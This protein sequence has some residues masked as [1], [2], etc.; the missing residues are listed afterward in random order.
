MAQTFSNLARDRKLS[1]LMPIAA[2]G[3]IG[4]G[5]AVW[6][7]KQALPPP[8][9]SFERMGHLVSLKVSY[10]DVIEF[11]ES[12]SLEIPWLQWALPY[13]GTKVL[14]IARGD[15]SFATDLRLA[16]YQAIDSPNRK[17]SIVLPAPVA[18][19]SR[20]NHASTSDGSTRIYA[21]S[22]QG[23]EAII[24]GNE[25]R[26]KAIQSALALGQQRIEETCLKQDAI[27]AAKSNAETILTASFHAI[28]WNAAIAWR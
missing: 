15:C 19:Q 24:P 23:V 25:N 18:F 16:G 17:V 12:R 27:M 20:L 5:A 1:W 22:N 7:K 10:S 11:T 26:T 3:A 28:G 21:I 9:I 2:A 8:L 13:A 4:V 6:V 14:L